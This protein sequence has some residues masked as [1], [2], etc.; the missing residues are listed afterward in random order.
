MSS[1]ALSH[2]RGVS[3]G[4]YMPKSGGDGEGFGPTATEGTDATPATKLH[5]SS[6]ADDASAGNPGGWWEE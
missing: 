6:A 1:T 5:K 2:H 3:Q 4:V